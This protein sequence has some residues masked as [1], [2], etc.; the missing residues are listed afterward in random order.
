M[1]VC[2]VDTH[3]LINVSLKAF[4]SLTHLAMS[5]TMSRTK[6]ELHTCSLYLGVTNLMHNQTETD[7]SL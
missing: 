2:Y 6:E 4:Q 1:Y 3:N 7:F 5:S